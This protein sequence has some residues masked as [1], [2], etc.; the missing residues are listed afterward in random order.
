MTTTDAENPV[1]RKAQRLAAQRAVAEIDLLRVLPALVAE[2]S[3]SEV[4]R[5]LGVT[6]EALREM[7]DRA[8]LLSPPAPGFSG[9]D[10][11]EI[12][13]RFAVGQLSRE[14]LV[15]ELSRW[16]YA[17][18]GLLGEP[19]ETEYKLGDW[20][21]YVLPALRHGLLAPGIYEEVLELTDQAISPQTSEVQRSSTNI[22]AGGGT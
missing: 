21:I 4:A 2:A 20:D 13:Q 15:E 10:P 12:A 18:G 9:A 14:Q 8:L 3:A 19:I 5:D 22:P 1:L 11:Y 16:P 17:E 7:L 6:T